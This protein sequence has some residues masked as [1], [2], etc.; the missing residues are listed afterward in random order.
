MRELLCR[1][2][3]SGFTLNPDKVVLAASEIKYL[4]HLISARWVKI[5]PERVTA[6]QDYPRPT[7]LKSLRRFIGMVGFYSRSIPGYGSVVVT[8]HELKRKGVP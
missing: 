5:L 7:N 3:R 6:I 2:Q 4:G 1:L 8:L